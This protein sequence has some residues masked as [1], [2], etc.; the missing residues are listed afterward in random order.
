MLNCSIKPVLHSRL[1]A[2]F[3]SECYHL[4]QKLLSP[5]RCLMVNAICHT[6]KATT[7]SVSELQ[8]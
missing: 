8:P 5:R 1:L 6:L 7:S 2:P 4:Q 3:I